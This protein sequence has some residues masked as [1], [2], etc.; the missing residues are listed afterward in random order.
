VG[1]N[2]GVC[3]GDDSTCSGEYDK[4][5]VWNGNNDSCWYIDIITSININTGIDFDSRLGT[6]IAAEDGFNDSDVPEYV[7][8]DCYKDI[9]DN[10]INPPSSYIDF[11]FPHPEW[12]D[13]IEEVYGTTDLTKDIRYFE[14]YTLLDMDVNTVIIVGELLY[15]PQLYYQYLIR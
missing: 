10:P 8:G 15:F 5:G 1:D 12:Q 14:E 7:C 3:D 9:L 6:H 2:C 4:C 13:E 11:Y